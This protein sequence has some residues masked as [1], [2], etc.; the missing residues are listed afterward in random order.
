MLYKVFIKTYELFYCYISHSVDFIL[1]FLAIEYQ[2]CQN[3]ISNIIRLT[4]IF[5]TYI[6]LTNLSADGNAMLARPV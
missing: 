4:N 1:Y 6:F 5:K 2:Y 3:Q